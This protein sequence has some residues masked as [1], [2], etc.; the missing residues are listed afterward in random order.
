MKKVIFL[1]IALSILSCKKKE[2]DD[3][4]NTN[5]TY[6]KS[7]KQGSQNIVVYTYNGLNQVIK[8]VTNYNGFNKETTYT[9]TNG[10]VSGETTK[11]NGNIIA[12][13][14]YSYNNTGKLN[15]CDVG[16]A[17]NTYWNFHYLNGNID[18]A[19]QVVGN[20]NAKKMTFT[21]QGDD[22]IEAKE[23]FYYGNIWELQKRYNFEYDSKN[24]PEYLMKMPFSEVM[25]ENVRF[26]CQNNIIRFKKYNNSGQLLEDIQFDYTYNNSNYPKTL[27]TGNT[28]M[29]Y[30]Y[31]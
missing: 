25:D 9:Y 27:V 6:L 4:S 14:T 8:K 13:Y 18:E 11:N 24:N 23:Y 19:A 21:Y 15:R 26:W 16:G 20:G 29:T 12:Q 22:I 3:S 31:K 30:I 10:K 1:F 7:I 28:N 2:A 5:G 17:T